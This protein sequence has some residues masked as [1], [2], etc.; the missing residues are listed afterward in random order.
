MVVCVLYLVSSIGR[1]YNQ[2]LLV[3]QK[4]YGQ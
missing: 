4:S 3:V 1:C 2:E